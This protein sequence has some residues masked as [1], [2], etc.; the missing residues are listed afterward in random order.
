MSIPPEPLERPPGYDDIVVELPI[1]WSEQHPP[2]L[3]D[4]PAEP[5]PQPGDEATIAT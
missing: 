3:P 4:L 2:E 1:P 5:E